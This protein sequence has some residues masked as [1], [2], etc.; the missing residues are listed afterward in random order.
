MH[1][2]V[3]CFLFWEETSP[4]LQ[5]KLNNS[6]C[7]VCVG[8]CNALSCPIFH[9][10]DPLMV[11]ITTCDDGTAW[12]RR[13]APGRRP[14][15]IAPCPFP[16]PSSHPTPRSPRTLLSVGKKQ[17]KR[18]KQ[19]KEKRKLRHVVVCCLRGGERYLGFDEGFGKVCVY[20]ASSFH[21]CG[22]SRNV[23]RTRFWGSH[24]KEH[25]FLCF[26]FRLFVFGRINV[27]DCLLT[28]GASI[29]LYYIK[30]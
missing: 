4:L 15:R 18:Q 19:R 7:V 28:T 17:K 22:S 20:D 26:V 5:K 10:R 11:P 13:P 6:T 27:Q 9:I 1:C 23:P 8:V 25:L 12:R 30:I 2:F 14:L 21:R 16:L 24:R 29:Y 3:F